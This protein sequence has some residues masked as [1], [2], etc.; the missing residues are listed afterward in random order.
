MYSLC[1]VCVFCQIG[2]HIL[3]LVGVLLQPTF[4]LAAAQVSYVFLASDF[5]CSESLVHIHFATFTQ[6][7]VHPGCFKA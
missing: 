2:F 5:S 3:C 4:F 6:N 1:S 7:A